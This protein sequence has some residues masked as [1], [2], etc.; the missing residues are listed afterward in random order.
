MISIQILLLSGHYLKTL[1]IEFNILKYAQ[2]SQY[3]TT[4]ELRFEHEKRQSAPS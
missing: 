4:A 2:Q 3:Q 1:I